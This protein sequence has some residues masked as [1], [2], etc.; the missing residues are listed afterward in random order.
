LTGSENTTILFLKGLFSIKDLIMI[1]FV[2]V[3][4]INRCNYCVKKDKL[5]E[6]LKKKISSF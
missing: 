4:I 3:S 5:S 2:N 6:E 1:N